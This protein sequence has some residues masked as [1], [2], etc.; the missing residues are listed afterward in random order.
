[1]T[2]RMPKPPRSLAWGES[3]RSR[4]YFA[5]PVIHDFVQPFGRSLVSSIFACDVNEV[6]LCMWRWNEEVMADTQ[7]GLVCRHDVLRGIVCV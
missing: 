6:I 3:S 1:M 5:I 4:K 7:L 2:D